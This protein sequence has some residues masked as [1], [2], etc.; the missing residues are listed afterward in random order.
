MAMAEQEELA[1]SGSGASGEGSL[2][3]QVG[4][5]GFYPAR[6]VE[7]APDAEK[8]DFTAI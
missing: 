7:V 3:C 5:E 1:W 6:V 4:L 8:I 2:P